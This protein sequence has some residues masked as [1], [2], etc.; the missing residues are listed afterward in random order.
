MLN[1]KDFGLCDYVGGF[2]DPV[3]ITYVSLCCR[4]ITWHCSCTD[5]S[6]TR[7]GFVPHVPCTRSRCVQML[8][9]S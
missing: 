5:A 1:T 6:R 3:T 9:W 4:F 8:S 2:A 7:S